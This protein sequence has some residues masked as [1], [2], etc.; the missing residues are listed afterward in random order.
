VASYRKKGFTLIELLVVIAIIAI[1]AAILFPVFAQA[2][3][4]ARSISCL[5]N[6]KQVGTGIQMYSQDYDETIVPWLQRTGLPRN[7]LARQDY[8][9]WVDL[10]QPYIKNGQPIRDPSY[11]NGAEVRALGMFACPSFNENTFI[12]S[13]IQ[14][15]CDGVGSIESWFPATQFFANY[16]IGFATGPTGT[17]VQN[18]PYFNFAGSTGTLNCGGQPCRTSIMG[19]AVVNRPAE[20]AI[21][22]DG[23]TGIIN[24]GGIGTTMGCEAAQAHTGGGNFTF[25]DGHAKWIARNAERY[26]NQDQQGCYYKKYFT[27][28]K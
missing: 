21:V 3:E 26:E 11:T 17:C 7:G 24:S 23:F 13:A 25:L 6:S 5:S 27:I 8:N 2:R 1:L 20:T 14:P 28:D 18:D 4:K 16:G 19:L 22:S 10:L 12:Q 15:D 9:S